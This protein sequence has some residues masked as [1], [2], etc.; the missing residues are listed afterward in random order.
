M[1]NYP[2]IL[3][4]KNMKVYIDACLNIYNYFELHYSPPHFLSIQFLNVIL[5]RHFV[6]TLMLVVVIWLVL[7]KKKKK[8]KIVTKSIKKTLNK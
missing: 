8:I 4:Q 7:L 1:I 2:Q 3:Y 5:L 6:V